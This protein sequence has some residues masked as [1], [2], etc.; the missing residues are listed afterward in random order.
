ML[1]RPP[2]HPALRACVAMLW[3][4]D[5]PVAD[6]VPAPVQHEMLLPTGATHIVLRLAAHPL[7]I[8]DAD[9]AVGWTAPPSLV[10][11]TRQRYHRR[12]WSGEQ[13][14]VGAML[15]P[16]GALALLGAPAGALA[17][18]HWALDDLW[19]ADAERL[20]QRL[21][22][23]DDAATR[24]VLFEQALLH[25]VRRLQPASPRA[26]LHP[27][28]AA[29]LA[30]LRPASHAA[31][32]TPTVAT[33][34]ATSGLSHRHFVQ[35]FVAAT[36]LRPKAGL[37]VLRL[38]RTLALLRRATPLADAAAALGYSDQSHL[39]REFVDLAGITPGD[40]LRT[41]PAQAHHVATGQLRPRPRT[42][43]PR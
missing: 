20:R 21:A 41:A 43:P 18:R 23:C 1:Q 5:G 17:G 10:G 25:R 40:Y 27:G 30:C 36:G 28:V 4:A 29:A 32:P 6:A 37:R 3:A 26:L 24:L 34:V 9:D 8:H 11:G 7:T 14:S 2:Y 22:A 39:A 35:L 42:R 31:T 19:G 33:L 38:Q 16:G 12:A 15:R 13:V